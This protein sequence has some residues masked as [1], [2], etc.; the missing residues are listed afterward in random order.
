[1]GIKQSLSTYN[2]Y[3]LMNTI[4]NF[5]FPKTNVKPILERVLHPYRHAILW[6]PWRLLNGCYKYSWG[7]QKTLKR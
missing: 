4:K 5:G 3:V 7:R 6:S 1:M 2:F